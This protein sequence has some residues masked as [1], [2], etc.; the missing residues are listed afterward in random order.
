MPPGISSYIL[1]TRL[2]I[3][4]FIAM[5]FFC[6]FD[7]FS[8]KPHTPQTQTYSFAEAFASGNT[9]AFEAIL[10][11]MTVIMNDTGSNNII[12]IE[13]RVLGRTPPRWDLPFPL[14]TIYYD[15]NDSVY[16]D[17]RRANMELV[18]TK[19]ALFQDMYDMSCK[20]YNMFAYVESQIVNVIC[21]DIN[22]NE[23]IVIHGLKQYSQWA[24]Q[25]N[26]LRS[27]GSYYEVNTNQ[28][29]TLRAVFDL[30]PKTMVLIHPQATPNAIYAGICG[31]AEQ[32]TQKIVGFSSILNKEEIKNKSLLFLAMFM[33][34]TKTGAHL[35]Y[36]AHDKQLDVFCKI[37]DKLYGKKI[38]LSTLYDMYNRYGHLSESEVIMALNS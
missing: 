5:H 26:I 15:N 35:E 11:Y 12:C 22:H 13:R 24:M 4:T 17:I 38:K 16:G 21:G 27:M 2:E 6:I 20:N 7:I 30:P 8:G 19:P 29:I 18:V 14:T 1:L 37:T 36:L 33:A 9:D 23:S 10:N 25:H 31:V 32:N 34:C 28:V 3:A